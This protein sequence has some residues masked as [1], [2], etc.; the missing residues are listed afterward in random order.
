MQY[1]QMM[2]TEEQNKAH[3]M[4]HFKKKN[5]N[6]SRRVNQSNAQIR[7]DNYYINTQ[8]KPSVAS[9]GSL[10]RSHRDSEGE[11]TSICP[12]LHKNRIPRSK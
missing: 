9:R 3:F 11:N 7:S 12:K 10:A 6:R 2:Q 4:K 5:W 1:V 8:N